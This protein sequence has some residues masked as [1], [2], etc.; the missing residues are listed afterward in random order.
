MTAKEL[1]QMKKVT[2]GIAAMALLFAG[3][4]QTAPSSVAPSRTRAPLRGSRRGTNQK[5]RL[6]RRHPNPPRFKALPPS[7]KRSPTQM[8]WS[9]R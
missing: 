1:R 3:C 2:V 8:G 7:T 6:A 9:S 5:N 4:A